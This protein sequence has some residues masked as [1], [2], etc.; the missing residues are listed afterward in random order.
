M[1][2]AVII[3]TLIVAA[4]LRFLY[5]DH[6][7]VEHHGVRQVETF[8]MAKNFYEERLP[9][10][11]SRFDQYGNDGFIKIEFPVYS[12]ILAKV[13]ALTGGPN[14]QAA[15]LFTITISLLCVWLVYLVV[16][17]VY[18]NQVA[19]LVAATVMAVNPAAVYFG[20][21]VQ[22]DSLMMLF[23]LLSLFFALIY[24][25]RRSQYSFLV[26]SAFLI[27]AGVIKPT[28]LI[29][30]P[31]LFLAVIDPVVAERGNFTKRLKSGQ[32]RWTI[33]G[34]VLASLIITFIVMV[35]W[36][37]KPKEFTSTVTFLNAGREWWLFSPDILKSV[38]Q[39]KALVALVKAVL[40][41]N[42]VGILIFFAGFLLSYTRKDLWLL[43]YLIGYSLFFVAGYP[44]H[45]VSS[46]DH[47]L[48]LAVPLMAFSAAKLYLETKEDRPK[49][50][51]DPLRKFLPTIYRFMPYALV[52]GFLA[53]VIPGL[54]VYHNHSKSRFIEQQYFEWASYVKQYTQK[55]DIIFMDDSF[56]L[57][58]IFHAKRRSLEYN[59]PLTQEKIELAKLKGASYLAILDTIFVSKSLT[60]SEKAL[61]EKLNPVVI[62]RDF[63]LYKL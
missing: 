31:A 55:D 18:G 40:G 52:I 24:Q 14:L 5:F 16:K 25:K 54:M 51:I 53:S 42:A 38:F 44:L 27:L 45:V 46:H 58:L 29:I 6:S 41:Y 3:I 28:A 48:I 11:K 37:I 12:Y 39:P 26:S 60:S 34:G 57:Y 10:W 2:N 61:L 8:T 62:T 19:A 4:G 35:Y 1:R 50:V 20:R 9:I 17:M 63:K 56:D 43:I 33:A 7:V 47:H 13:F 15:R 30:L 21:T 59:S 23:T 36:S 49:F 22:P 32:G